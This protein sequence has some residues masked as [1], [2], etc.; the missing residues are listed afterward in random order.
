MNRKKLIDLV[1]NGL[2]EMLGEARVGCG[3]AGLYEN[4]ITVTAFAFVKWINFFKDFEIVCQVLE[5]GRVL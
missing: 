1:L 3:A 5:L 4:V 2:N